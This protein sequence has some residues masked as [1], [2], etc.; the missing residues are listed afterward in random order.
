MACSAKRFFTGSE[1]IFFNRQCPFSRSLA[2]S[3][4]IRISL[5]VPGPR[6]QF[7]WELMLFVGVVAQRKKTTG[8]CTCDRRCRHLGRSRASVAQQK[9]SGSRFLLSLPRKVLLHSN[10]YSA[11]RGSGKN[12]SWEIVSME[13]SL[14]LMHVSI[15]RL[16]PAVW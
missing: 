16:S 4:G 1:P 13:K 5:E 2:A 7:V 3:P 6:E 12:A 15:W 14:S 9:G 11:G 10:Q 8:C